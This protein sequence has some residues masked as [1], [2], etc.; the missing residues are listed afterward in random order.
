[1][2]VEKTDEGRPHTDA[3]RAA[4]D[5]ADERG[6]RPQSFLDEWIER[7]RLAAE[8]V[9]W[10]FRTGTDLAATRE[11]GPSLAPSSDD[12]ATREKAAVVPGSE[13]EV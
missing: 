4:E 10:R 9:L 2:D 3:D 11:P 6:E 1:M 5:V 12:E 8:G 7:G 13:P